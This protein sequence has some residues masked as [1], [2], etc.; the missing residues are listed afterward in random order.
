MKKCKARPLKTF[1]KLQVIYTRTMDL[2]T[3]SMKQL[4][5]QLHLFVLVE[6]A[7]TLYNLSLSE[8]NSKHFFIR[9]YISFPNTSSNKEIQSI[10]FQAPQ[11]CLEF[12]KS[13]LFLW[14]KTKPILLQKYPTFTFI[15]R[16]Q[17]LMEPPFSYFWIFHNIFLYTQLALAFCF[18][19]DSYSVH[20]HILYFCFSLLQKDIDT[21]FFLNLFFIFFFDN[22]WLMLVSLFLYIRQ[23]ISGKKL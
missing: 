4:Y 18:L 9:K 23:K 14:L 16:N 7:V 3:S 20:D 1:L 8:K 15:A 19:R 13:L 6:I 21:R 5:L 22:I 2:Q 12:L 10:L 11:I 17:N